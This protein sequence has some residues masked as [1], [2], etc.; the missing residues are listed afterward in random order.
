MGNDG[1]C[2]YIFMFPKTKSVWKGLTEMRHYCNLNI[3]ACTGFLCNEGSNWQGPFHP[4]IAYDI[5]NYRV[6]FLWEDRPVNNN[7]NNNMWYLCCVIWFLTHSG[8]IRVS[9][10]AADGLAPNKTEQHYHTTAHNIPC[11]RY[12]IN[13]THSLSPPCASMNPIDSSPLMTDIPLPLGHIFL[14]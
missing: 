13:L 7:N 3:L 4:W 14:F 6:L 12:H 1:N 2:K 10:V 9:L 11:T 8:H 5:E